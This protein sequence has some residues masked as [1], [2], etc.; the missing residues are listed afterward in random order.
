L[1]A[2]GIGTVSDDG[3]VAQMNETLNQLS[4]SKVYEHVMKQAMTPWPADPFGQQAFQAEVETQIPA[5]TQAPRQIKA[6]YT[7]FIKMGEKTM[8]IINGLEYESGETIDPGGL[9][10]EQ[11][12]PHQVILRA[13]G[14]GEKVTVPMEEID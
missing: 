13:A 4:A 3:F 5:E 14:Q 11:I 10:V 12:A 8:A 2:K 7:G 9:V 1:P 6:V